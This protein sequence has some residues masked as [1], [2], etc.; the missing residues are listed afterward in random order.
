MVKQLKFKRHFSWQGAVQRAIDCLIVGFFFLGAHYA[1]IG[2]WTP[3]H[4]L[5]A[6][7]GALVFLLMSGFRGMYLPQDEKLRMLGYGLLVTTWVATCS[8]LLL[9][10]YA[11]KTS[12]IFSRIAVAGWILGTPFLMIASRWMVGFLF[13]FVRM[14]AQPRLVALAGYSE[15]AKRFIDSLSSSAEPGL[16][17]G[18]LYFSANVESG[19]R[20]TDK[21][22]AKGDLDNLIRDVRKGLYDEVYIAMEM[23]E[24]DN[25]SRLISELSDCSIPVFFIP[26][27]FTMNLLAS[28]LYHLEGMPII[29]IY[30]SPMDARDVA[31]KRMEDVILSLLILAVA[32]VPMLSVAIAIKI[33]SRGPVIFRQ[34]RY[35][36]S[37]EAIEIWKFR[38]MT[39]CDDGKLIVQAKK[40]DERLTTLGAFLRRTSLDELP[41]F[42]N[43]LKGD[44][45]IVGPRPHAVAHNEIYRKEIRGYMLRHLVKPGITGWAQVNGWRGETDTLEKMEMRV[46]YDLEY[47]KY[48][49]IWFDL[50]IIVMTIFKGFFHKNAY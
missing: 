47:I 6:L 16:E 39:V 26:D 20:E 37:G 28:Q 49:S 50:K 45:S 40:N 4:E 19:L 29:S 18:G 36:M 27:I 14:K 5:A 32:A 23:S 43:V 44:M 21:A 17:L 10:A 41:Q 31:I 11:T 30:D 8:V 3:F 35:G 9:L 46:K 24:E 2:G 25:I 12:S 42:F 22:L 33:T 13:S 1:Y 34:R 7:V 48:W 38:S 15:N